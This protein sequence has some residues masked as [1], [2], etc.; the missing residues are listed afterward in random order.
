MVTNEVNDGSAEMLKGGENVAKEMQKLDGLTRI[1]TDSMNE[2]ASG[3]MQISNAVQDV[4]EI[5]KKNTRLKSYLI[6]LLLLPK[7]SKIR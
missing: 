6:I 5:S 3:A 1:I 4:N 7:Q 2:M